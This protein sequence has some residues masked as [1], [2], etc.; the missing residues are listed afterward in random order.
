MPRM[1]KEGKPVSN[2]YDQQAAA[3]VLKAVGALTA[4]ELAKTLHWPRTR[5]RK[6]LA[7]LEADG[8]VT[9]LHTRAWKATK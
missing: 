5:T 6:A 3:A 4:A 7:A 2:T 8:R 1:Q 9:H